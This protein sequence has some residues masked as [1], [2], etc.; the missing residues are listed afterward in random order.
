MLNESILKLFRLGI[1]DDESS[2]TGK[3]DFLETEVVLYGYLEIATPEFAAMNDGEYGRLFRFFMDDADIDV[4]IG[5]RLVDNDNPSL[6]YNVSGVQINDRGP[7]RRTEI[8][9]HLP[10]P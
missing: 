4:R 3:R 2:T 5:D 1:P 7:Q 6:Y 10:K 8:V 9:C